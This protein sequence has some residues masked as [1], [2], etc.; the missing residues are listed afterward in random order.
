MSILELERGNFV[1]LK[2]E[3]TLE[4]VLTE[5]GKAV[6][7]LDI[8]VRDVLTIREVNGICIW[9]RVTFKDSDVVMVVKKVEEEFDVKVCFTPDGFEPGDRR[10]L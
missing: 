10:D 6:S 9:Q 8:E 7:G 1:T 2:D 3:Q 4:D 5:T